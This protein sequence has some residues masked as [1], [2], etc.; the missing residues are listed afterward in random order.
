M[1]KMQHTGFRSDDAGAT[2]IEYSIIAAGIAAVIVTS[3]NLLGGTV[4]GMYDR[5]VTAL[6]G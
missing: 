1:N 5:V 4:S 2:A 6:G 3:V